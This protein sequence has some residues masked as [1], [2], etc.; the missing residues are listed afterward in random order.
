MA[1][2][3][4]VGGKAGSE[5]LR[6]PAGVGVSVQAGSTAIGMGFE[7]PT[8]VG[9]S[10]AYTCRQTTDG[11]RYEPHTFFLG[12]TEGRWF[13]FSGAWYTTPALR[14]VR[15]R[16]MQ[17]IALFCFAGSAG[18]GRAWFAEYQVVRTGRPC[19]RPLARAK[20]SAAR[21]DGLGKGAGRLQPV[22]VRR[23]VQGCRGVAHAILNLLER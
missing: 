7:R 1:G 17:R 21:G 8:N 14:V 19:D 13:G 20:P 4:T 6:P 3:H 12:S 16:A 10:G 23:E 15:K 2:A 9:W 5:H 22:L 11:R 18:L